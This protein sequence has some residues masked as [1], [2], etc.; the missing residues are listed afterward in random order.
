MRLWRRYLARVMYGALLLGVFM[1][2][3]G[4][5]WRGIEMDGKG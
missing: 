2:D 5:G 4:A 1:W 3:S